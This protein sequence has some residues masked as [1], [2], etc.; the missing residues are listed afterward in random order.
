MKQVL[1]IRFPPGVVWVLIGV[2][3]QSRTGRVNSLIS[4]TASSS[5]INSINAPVYAL[6]EIYSQWWTRSDVGIIKDLHHLSH[7]LFPLL[8]SG[9]NCHN[10]PTPCLNMYWCLFGKRITFWMRNDK[11]SNFVIVFCGLIIP[12]QQILN[13]SSSQ[14][15]RGRR[16][17]WWSWKW[18]IPSTMAS[19]LQSSTFFYLFLVFIK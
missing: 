5:T 7:G 4:A 12:C 3:Y 1:R 11:L 18:C 15:R 13:R 16:T 17:V 10:P 14:D 19:I 6:P 9:K 2:N 8:F